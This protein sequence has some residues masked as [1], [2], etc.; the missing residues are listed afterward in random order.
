[1]F[2]QG[3]K[4]LELLASEAGGGALSLINLQWRPTQRR[5]RFRTGPSG[6]RWPRRLRRTQSNTFKHIMVE[7]LGTV[8]N[9]RPRSGLDL[10]SMAVSLRPALVAECVH[11]PRFAVGRH[12]GI[13]R[14]TYGITYRWF[15]ASAKAPASTAPPR[16][17]RAGGTC[18]HASCSVL[19][20]S[21]PLSLGGG[22]SVGA[23]AGSCS[24]H[25][26]LH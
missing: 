18:R 4:K 25:R 1:M 14:G 23:V 3:N 17:A 20:C 22:S 5:F 8:D 2:P 10:H 9:F 15:T 19:P 12:I 21:A 6:P 26:Q 16:P 7:N 13:A 24:Q 11:V